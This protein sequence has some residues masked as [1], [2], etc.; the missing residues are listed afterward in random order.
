[1]NLPNKLTILRIVLVVPLIV[2]FSLSYWSLN[3]KNDYLSFIFLNLAGSIFVI[4]M[5]TDFL[6]G[7][8]ARKKN[9]ITTFGKL[10][11]PLADK[12]TI[13]VTLIFLAMFHYSSFIFVI[14][15]IIRDLVV[16]GSRNIIAKHNLKFEANIFGKLKTVFQTIAIIILI[17]ASHFIDKKSWWQ[18][19]LINFPMI[20]ASLMSY[21]SG[22]I[23]FKKII[24]YIKG[25]K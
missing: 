22:I 8:L 9:E 16:D 2:F 17:F 25:D 24:P 14:L 11:D 18:M 20:I 21:F 3:T 15:F 7:Y 23:Y 13:N 1:M 6:D 10:F 12:I 4:S 5:I 19:L